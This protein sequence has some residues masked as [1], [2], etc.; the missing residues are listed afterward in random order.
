MTTTITAPPLQTLS[1]AAASA[2]LLQWSG[3]VGFVAARTAA[4]HSQ[5]RQT[6]QNDLRRD[7][8]ARPPQLTSRCGFR[9][10]GSKHNAVPGHRAAQEGRAKPRCNRTS[11]ITLRYEETV[12][13][14]TAT[15]QP[16]PPR[17][18]GKPAE[19]NSPQKCSVRVSCSPVSPF[20]I[21]AAIDGATVSL[22]VHHCSSYLGSHL[23]P[24]LLERVLDTA[25]RTTS[26]EVALGGRESS[27]PNHQVGE[28]ARR[29]PVL[30]SL[31]A[32]FSKTKYPL[33]LTGLT[34]DVLRDAVTYVE[35][36]FPVERLSTLVLSKRKATRGT[37][38]YLLESHVFRRLLNR[39]SLVSLTL[40]LN[41]VT[42][43]VLK[44]IS[45][46]SLQE[47]DVCGGGHSEAQVVQELCGLPFT[48]ADQV[49]EA[50]RADHLRDLPMTPLRESLRRLTVSL[51]SLP[52]AMYQVFLA[53]FHKLHHYSPPSGA[54]PCVSGYARMAGPS[55]AANP[56]DL[57]SLKLGY[58]CTHD[59]LEMARVCPAL[60]D[61]SLSIEL[62]C[63]EALSSLGTCERLSGVQLSYYPPSVSAPPKVEGSVLLSLLDFLGP[64][65]LSLGLTGFSLRSGVVTA[66]AGLP[67]LRRLTLTDCW[68]AH[69]DAAPCHSF[70]SLDTLILNFMPPLET[71]RLLTAGSC[72]HSL[73]INMVASEA[74]GNGLTD[75]N[76]R[77]LISS[78][79]ISSIHRFSSSS[80]F[81]TLAS[82]RPL[83][84]LPRLRSVG[85]LARWGITEEELRCMGHSGPP[86]LLCCP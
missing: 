51:P 69:P 57:L 11:G 85:C 4:T 72:L 84:A 28:W 44:E 2:W 63:E 32:C 45:Q 24:L 59:I 14:G 5:Q 17:P 58:A 38:G 52:S 30:L 81:L 3:L 25:W 40:S 65:L 23:P 10:H 42:S 77:Q 46:L 34:Q 31:A 54:R 60:R 83:A 15:T 80:P 36:H 67:E 48:T 33:E 86:H 78:C 20:C 37:A 73:D 39:S 18:I 56:L 61:V 71:L 79:A 7:T 19:Q 16:R 41:A 53:V 26:E 50:V 13:W 6:T 68:L 47:L 21:P 49:V 27:V 74:H 35:K 43:S 62:D 76:L 1:E 29:A 55:G 12:P 9:T 66:L 64:R 75:T 82:L 22:N 8:P 70:S